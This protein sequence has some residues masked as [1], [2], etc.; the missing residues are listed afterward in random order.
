MGIFSLFLVFFQ[1]VGT[2]SDDVFTTCSLFILTKASRGKRKARAQP[3]QC[4]LTV[5]LLAL[6][7]ILSFL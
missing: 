5:C 2:G 4:K 1:Y 7:L 3:E 6:T